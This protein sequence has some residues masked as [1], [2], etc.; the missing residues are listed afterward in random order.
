MACIIDN[1]RAEHGTL[2]QLIRLLDGRQIV[3][4]DASPEKTALL[5]DALYYLTRFPDVNH[6]VIE[7]RIVEKLLEKR[8]LPAALRSEVEA[9]HATLVREGHELLQ[10]LESMVREENMSSEWIDLHLR[11]YGERLRHNMAMEELMLFP[12]AL[13]HLEPQDW[14]A[15]AR[16]R[17]EPAADPFIDLCA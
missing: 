8:A 17:P 15:I 11:L 13:V 16:T 7:N 10:A 5:V 3:F 12:M 4:G 6:H 14:D 9:Q 2:E 1:L